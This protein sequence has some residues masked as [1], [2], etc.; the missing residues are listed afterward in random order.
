MTLV[1]AVRVGVGLVRREFRWTNRGGEEFF[2]CLSAFWFPQ[3]WSVIRGK[4]VAE[5][6]EI[7]VVCVAL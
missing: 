5:C 2:Y 4:V 3:Q 6:F 7:G 1:G